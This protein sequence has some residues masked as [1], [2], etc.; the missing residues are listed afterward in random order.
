MRQFRDF[1]LKFAPHVVNCIKTK[2]L[3]TA[4]RAVITQIYAVSLSEFVRIGPS[5]R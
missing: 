2:H 5:Q 4:H 3:P 1:A